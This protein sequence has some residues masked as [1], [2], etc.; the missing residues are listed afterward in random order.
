MHFQTCA[1][2]GRGR[3][4]LCRSLRVCLHSGW[5]DRAANDEMESNICRP[6]PSEVG[7]E[8]SIR[9]IPLWIIDQ[10]SLGFVYCSQKMH[11]T[12]S[13]ASSTQVWGAN[14]KLPHTK[15]GWHKHFPFPCFTFVSLFFIINLKKESGTIR[16]CSSNSPI[17]EGQHRKQVIAFQL[18]KIL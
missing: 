14:L 9:E 15:Q 10:T 16:N 4:E 6:G 1:V 12:G 3:V 13:A 5:T 2:Q 7:G 18:W 8:Q 17:P 11:I